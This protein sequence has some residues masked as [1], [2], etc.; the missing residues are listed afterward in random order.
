MLVGYHKISDVINHNVCR[1]LDVVTSGPTPPNPSELLGNA[2]MD[3]LIEELEAN[4]DLIILDTPPVNIVSDA[5]VLSKFVNE[6]LLVSRYEFTK[7]PL[8]KTAVENLHFAKANIIGAVLVDSKDF[9][10]GYGKYR[11]RYK[12]YGRYAES[13]FE[14]KYGKELNGKKDIK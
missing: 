11:Y 3:S 8:V 14:A 10:K 7:I 12:Y 6:V 13:T 9:S 2:K 1:N 5:L 4:Y